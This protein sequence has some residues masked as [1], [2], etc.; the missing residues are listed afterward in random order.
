MKQFFPALLLLLC[1]TACQR[2]VSDE[3]LEPSTPPTTPGSFTAKINGVPWTADKAAAATFA[4]GSNGIPD[5]INIVGL[6]SDKKLITITLADSGVHNYTLSDQTFNVAAFQDSSLASAYV[7]ATN[8][9]L[10]QPSGTVRLT[11]INTDKKTV[12]GTF[13]L[14]V[15]R[16]FDNDARTITDGVF[17]DIPYIE[18]TGIPPASST[19]TFAV[20]IDGT[21]F[22]PF[23]IT[24]FSVALTNSI[25]VQGG[26]EEGDKNVGVTFPNT[27]VPGTYTLDVF[28]ATHL[29]L[30]NTGTGTLTSLSGTLKILEHDK[31]AKRV[32]G[33]FSFKGE[34][35]TGALT[36][37]QLTDGYFAVTYQ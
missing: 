37:A 2:E 12:S 20:T 25:I 16:Q 4:P 14:N 9:A 13:R 34:D 26:T 24:G 15:Y 36:P 10:A 5:L 6:G 21:P 29:A 27:I 11:A 1:L 23:T 32:R 3:V 7:F 22:V 30:Y 8:Q 19:D 28:G 33:N 18:G 31:T 35:I 17:T